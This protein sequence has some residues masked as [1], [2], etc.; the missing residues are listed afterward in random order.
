M[1]QKMTG[2]ISCGDINGIG[3]EITLKAIDKLLQVKDINYKIVIPGNVFAEAVELTKI[4]LSEK[5][6]VEIVDIGT[7][8]LR[9][10]EPTAASGE[11]SYRA[12]EKAFEIVSKDDQAFLVTAPISKYAF[13]LAGVDFPGHTELLAEWDNSTGFVMTFLSNQLKCALATIHIPL[14]KV[15]RDLTTEKLRMCLDT[16]SNSLRYDFSIHQPKIAVLGLNPHAGE[17]GL[18]GSEE[19]DT[20]IPLLK[21]FSGTVEGPFP[22]DAFFARKQY[23]NFDMF[24]ALY[25]D[26]GLIPF[27]LL[28]AGSGVN[29]TAGLNIIRTSPDHGTA[30]DIAWQ[31]KA[32]FS[33]MIE[34]IDWGHRI[35]TNRRF[36]YGK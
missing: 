16:I 35:S 26:Q 28:T 25:H 11:A 34:A 12:L 17:N 31:N 30:H 14:S 18:L 33:S 36:I 7:F 29:F 5:R 21:E 13:S 23:L 3:P 20:I 27:K 4:D 2:V 32:D 15:S 19:N 1:I 9:K 24:V 10:G 22:A 6:N 8:E